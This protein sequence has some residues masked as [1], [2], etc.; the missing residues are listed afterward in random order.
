[1]R[2]P[3]S[4]PLRDTP[5]AGR[6]HDPRLPRRRPRR[7][8]PR[9]R[10]RL[11]R[12]PRAGRH[13]RRR[14]RR[15]DGGGVV[16]RRRPAGRRGRRRHDAR[17]P[18]DQGALGDR[19]RDLR[20]RHRAGGPGPWARQGARARRAPPPRRAPGR[21]GAPLRRVRQRARG[22]ALRGA[23][24]HARRRRHPRDVRPSGRSPSFGRTCSPTS[25]STTTSCAAGSPS[26]SSCASSGDVALDQGQRDRAE[27]VVAGGGADEPDDLVRR[28]RTSA[29]D[30]GQPVLEPSRCSSVSRRGGRPSV[31][32]RATVSWPR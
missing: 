13:G 12:A 10:R 8:D 14:P 17:L 22:G 9:Q 3:T 25:G 21:R 29:P 27:L 19:G 11:R 1:M 24:L 20:A 32:T 28:A 16:R 7:P 30:R 6:G 26:A 31:C 18:L 5:L 23:G 2:R 15:P 4:L